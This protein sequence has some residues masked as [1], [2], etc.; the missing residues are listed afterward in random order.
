MATPAARSVNRIRDFMVKLRRAVET[1]PNLFKITLL[2][3]PPIH[4]PLP[5]LFCLLINPSLPH[6]LLPS[7]TGWLLLLLLLLLLRPGSCAKY[8]RMPLR[9][10]SVRQSVGRFVRA[11]RRQFNFGGVGSVGVSGGSSTSENKREAGGRRARALACARM[12]RRE[13]LKKQ[14][15]KKQNPPSAPQRH[16]CC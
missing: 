12:Q 4:P 7:P 9:L 15:T 6:P 11:R 16:T 13:Q 10:T 14:I 3:P 5:L 8:L 2:L 1:E